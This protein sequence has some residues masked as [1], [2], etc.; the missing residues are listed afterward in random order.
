MEPRPLGPFV[1]IE[2]GRLHNEISA[3][4]HY[5]CS[6]PQLIPEDVLNRVL[7]DDHSLNIVKE[8]FC[9]DWS[10]HDRQ[11][12]DINREDLSPLDPDKIMPEALI[13]QVILPSGVIDLL[14]RLPD[15]SLVVLIGRNYDYYTKRKEHSPIPHQPA[16]LPLSAS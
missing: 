16:Q 9:E 15:K 13:Y 14:R 12:V 6:Q 3:K 1:C 4:E 5:C 7:G 8:I 2:C 11:A 10:D